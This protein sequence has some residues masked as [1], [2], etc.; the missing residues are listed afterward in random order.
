[1]VDSCPDF[2]ESLKLNGKKRGPLPDYLPAQPIHHFLGRT[3][4]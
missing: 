3:V 2:A 1:M 4:S